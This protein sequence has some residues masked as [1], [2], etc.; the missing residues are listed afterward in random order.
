MKLCGSDPRRGGGSEARPEGLG[1]TVGSPKVAAPGLKGVDTGWGRAAG[2]GMR[3]GNA[4][5][6]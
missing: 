2:A 6:R 3:E 5:G 1:L 4:W